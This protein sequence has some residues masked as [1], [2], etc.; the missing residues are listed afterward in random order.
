MTSSKNPEGNGIPMPTSTMLRS[1]YVTD[2]VQT[3]SPGRLI[4]ALYDR[5][6]LDLDRAE[7]AIGVHDISASHEALVHAQEILYELLGSLDTKRWPAGAPL[8]AIYQYAINELV[9]ANVGKDVARVIACR[10]LLEPLRD[11]WRQAAGM[12][13]ETPAA[14]TA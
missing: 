1:R 4:V 13:A 2:A 7:A 9:A 6:M 8:L 11:A 12:T 5:F 14:R 3:M 10:D